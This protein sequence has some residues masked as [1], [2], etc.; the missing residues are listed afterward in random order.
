M[1]SPPTATP[2]RILQAAEALFIEHGYAATSLRAVTAGAGVNLA[3]VHYHFGS[4]EGL[5]QAAI[6][7]RMAPVNQERMKRLD[8]L[9]A[10]VGGEAPALEDILEA[11]LAPVFSGDP[12]WDRTSVARLMGRLFGESQAFVLPLIVD[13]F[14]DVGRRFL[15][16]VCRA[17][18]GIRREELTWR[19]H[20]TIGAMI[21]AISFDGPV[22]ELPDSPVPAETGEQTVRRIVRY[23]A[24]GLRDHTGATTE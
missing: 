8:E 17:L 24:A 6:H 2:E 14:G 20:L 9:H 1:S 23:A 4:K 21:V 3:A 5:F 19:L 16:A 10:G 12:T 15:A 13:E 7:R 22:I 18:P 11:F